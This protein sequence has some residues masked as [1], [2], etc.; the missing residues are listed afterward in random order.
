MLARV[1]LGAHYPTDTVGSIIATPAAAYLGVSLG[2]LRGLGV[3]ALR[4]ANRRRARTAAPPATTDVKILLLHANGMG[5]TIRAVYNL[6]G[7][8]AADHDVEIVSIVRTRPEPFFEVP[9][10]VRITYLDDRVGRRPARFPALAPLWRSR[11]MPREEAA[12]AT[13]TLRTDL[14]LARFLRGLRG[15]VL[16][17]T[18]P[19]LNLATALLAPPGVITI[20][21]EHVGL[22]A[23]K[24]PIRKLIKR[25][26][27]RLG[28]LVTLTEADLDAYRDALGERAPARLLRIP[29]AI[30]PLTGGPSPLDTPAV[31]AVGRL[32][33]VK[34]FDLLIA[35][36]ERVVADHPG[37][38]LRIVGAGRQQAMLAAA[39]EKRGLSG[40]VELPG[41]RADIGAEL[42]HASIFA[43]SSRHEGFSMTIVEAL[44][45]GVPVVSFDCPHGPR[46]I[47]TPGCDGLLVPAGDTAAM[48]E[49]LG[50]L[51]RDENRRRAM[52]AKALQTARRY[53]GA[54]IG[55]RW[56]KLLEDLG[57]STRW[58]G[59]AR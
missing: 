16:I 50:G 18:R 40:S 37:W 22:A 55:A 36:W 1:Y 15:G 45:K 47:L 46:E 12:Y 53:D 11:L 5:G 44:S 19:G 17:T 4:A 6:A 58:D 25:R 35:A 20:A 10:G 24:P 9:E 39:I 7:D 23:H 49:A 33:R 48:A 56:R 34:G 21:Q 59:L 52:G 8:L 2:R 26:Y 31:L 28:A 54:L 32:T 41:R 14:K 51:I 29:N 30:T 13:F 43:L 57:R 3:P 42:D 38:K 27:G